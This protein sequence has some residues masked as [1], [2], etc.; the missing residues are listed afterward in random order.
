MSESY[1]SPKVG[2]VYETNVDSLRVLLC[3]R[4]R[5]VF[6]H[7][8]WYVYD[9]LVLDGDHP[10]IRTWSDYFDSFATMEKTMRNFKFKKII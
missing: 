2:D 3:I 6:V 8:G 5:E 10:P 4:V 7:D 1:Q 9:F